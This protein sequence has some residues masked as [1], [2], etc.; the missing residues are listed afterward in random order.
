MCGGGGVIDQD[1]A[2]DVAV[3]ETR[4]TKHRRLQVAGRHHTDVNDV[5]VRRNCCSVL[6]SRHPMICH[7]GTF[8]GNDV[9]AV[10]RVAQLQQ[11]LAERAAHQAK[12]DESDRWFAHV[13]IN[14]FSSIKGRGV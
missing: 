11:A 2:G 12:A 9:V 1:L 13:D 6:V 3:D 5:C 7:C 4:F 14:L 8:I 10:Y